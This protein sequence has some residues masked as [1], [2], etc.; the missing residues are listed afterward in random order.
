Q[1]IGQ[2]GERGFDPAAGPGHGGESGQPAGGKSAG[3]GKIR[4]TVLEP[5]E[6]GGRLGRGPRRPP[7]GEAGIGRAIPRPGPQARRPFVEGGVWGGG[8]GAGRGGRAEGKPPTAGP[9]PPA[10]R[11]PP[12]A[13]RPPP[14]APPAATRRAAR[15]PRGRADRAS[16]GRPN[17]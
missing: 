9:P 8:G 5:I 14:P 15:A 13:P 7:W 1:R 11:A 2:A 4:R 17:G 6:R 16:A 3:L 10:P 12:P